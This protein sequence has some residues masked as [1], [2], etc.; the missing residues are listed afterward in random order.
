MILTLI[1]WC[2]ISLLAFIVG[3]GFATFLKHIRG[4]IAW[5]WDMLLMSGV[6]LLTVYA[7]FYSLFGGVG[8]N[9][10]LLLCVSCVFIVV[11]CR[12]E[13]TLSFSNLKSRIKINRKSIF[14]CIALMAIIVMFAI[15]SCQKAGHADTDGY[16]AQAIHWIE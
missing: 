10:N 3:I 9:A 8:R 12:K 13:I 7:Q 6:M 16:H 4:S 1:N 14:W 2:Y 5:E 11:I 15:I